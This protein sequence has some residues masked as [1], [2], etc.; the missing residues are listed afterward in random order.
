MLNFSL[1]PDNLGG[2]CVCAGPSKSSTKT[3]NA[4]PFSLEDFFSIFG[5]TFVLAYAEDTLYDF[6]LKNCAK[7]KYKN[8]SLLGVTCFE[9]WVEKVL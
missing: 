6:R 3:T 2:Y 9:I 8:D 5:P 1:N 7:C 4:N